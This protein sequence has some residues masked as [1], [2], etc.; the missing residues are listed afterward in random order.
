MLERLKEAENK[1]FLGHKGEA[2][3]GSWTA[4]AS[5]KALNDGGAVQ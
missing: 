5:A 4:A 2:T 3:R 1:S